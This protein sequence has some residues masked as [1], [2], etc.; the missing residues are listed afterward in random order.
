MNK[1]LSLDEKF[2]KAETINPAWERVTVFSWGDLCEMRKR[3]A[4]LEQHSSKQACEIV[5]LHERLQLAA[6]MRSELEQENERLREIVQGSKTIWLEIAAEI[7]ESLRVNGG[8]ASQHWVAEA[9]RAELE[10]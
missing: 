3:I 5:G 6:N 1:D 4:E 2:Q 8:P 7:A 9:I 10:I